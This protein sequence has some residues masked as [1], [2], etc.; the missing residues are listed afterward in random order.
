LLPLHGIDVARGHVF[1]AS[2]MFLWVKTQRHGLE[3]RQAHPAIGL[4]DAKP[5][6]VK[7]SVTYDVA[8]SMRL[9]QGGPMVRPPDVGTKLETQ[10]NAPELNDAALN[11]PELNEPELNDPLRNDPVLNDPT[12]RLW[13]QRL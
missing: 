13:T 7:P 12:Q 4:H 5:C 9:P 2:R 6:H 3:G 11:E 10:L 1:F 8:R